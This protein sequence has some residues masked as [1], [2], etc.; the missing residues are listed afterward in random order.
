[1]K[2][3]QIFLLLLITSKALVAQE[4]NSERVNIV[5][6]INPIYQILLSITDDVAN[7]NLII[8]PGISEH[9]YQL[10]KN[11]VAVISKAN[12]IFYIDDALEHS[13]AKLVKNKSSYRLSKIPNL[14][15]LRK[16][17]GS[18]RIDPH[19]WL[20]P[21]N[22]IK[23]A[24]FMT[25]KISEIDQENSQTYQKNLKIFKVDIIKAAKDI[26]LQDLKNKESD[27]IFY[28]DGYQY[29]EDY[30]GLKP[31]KVI[32]SNHDR[33]LSIKDARDINIL[34][35]NN[36]IGCI[37]GDISDEKNSSKKLA[38]K[39]HVK[40]IELDLI[41]KKEESYKLIMLNLISDMNA[42][43]IK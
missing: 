39:Y 18:N 23:I 31:L 13:F 5:A 43:W 14:K 21:D 40:F 41:G 38:E 27:Y 34:A 28:H 19:I 36:K 32:F 8:K 35:R 3:I 4:L 15:L 29:F 30:F 6:S 1:M 9:D 2:F 26:R 11:D 12:L 10:R 33:E 42:C 7:A 17:D 16:R 25:D 20:N 37:F 22:A 24:E